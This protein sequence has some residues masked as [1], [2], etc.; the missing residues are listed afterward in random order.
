MKMELQSAT[1][2][3]MSLMEYK[4][5]TSFKKLILAF[6]WTF[7][8]C[9]SQN[10]MAQL[11]NDGPFMIK[12]GTTVSIYFDY[13]NRNSGNFINDGELHIF[14]N[15]NNDG[16]VSFNP[17]SNGRTFF[18]GFQE[19]LI[20]GNSISSF[21]NLIFDN[22]S[23]AIPFHLA[24]TIVVAKKAYFNY[25]IVQADAYD[26]RVVFDEIASHENASNHSFVDGQVEKRGIE[27]FQFPVGDVAFFRPS[28]TA[29]LQQNSNFVTQYFYQNSSNFFSHNLKEDEIL[30]IN[31][32][33][34]WVVDAQQGIDIVLSLSIDDETT[35]T[36]FL[37]ENSSSQLAI[38]KWDQ[39]QSKWVTLGGIVS[40]P[41]AGG[42]YQKLI[43][44][45]TSNFGV[46]TTALV[47]KTEPEI[48]DLVI[49]NGVTPN[50]D[51]LNDNFLIKG[52][53]NY[54]DNTVE[55][56]NRWGVKVYE[57][58]SYNES[59]NMFKGYSDGRVTVNRGEG[60]PTGTYYY[61]LKYKKS[62]RIVEKAGYLY[63]N[64]Q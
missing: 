64:R 38:V 56:Y 26:G 43:T 6:I 55:I 21:R 59:D 30:A 39:N 23:S 19:Q 53:E 45:S 7:T 22:S 62:N 10:L 57:T 3:D 61:I 5:V 33:E 40:D 18:T 28:Y 12:G 48:Q 20:E 41:S 54:P 24:T 32:A 35:P 15:W 1:P 9:L 50:G 60:L 4:K 37:N 17:N 47:K 14:Q 25:G 16:L 2:K 46:F 52:I 29:G 13:L 34:Y 8:I 36:E 27:A 51:G 42:D 44:A 63:L 11:V 31:N 49:Y 58:I